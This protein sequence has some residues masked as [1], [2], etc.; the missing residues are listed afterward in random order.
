MAAP[1]LLEDLSLEQPPARARP[2]KHRHDAARVLTSF[3]V[4]RISFECPRKCARSGGG[5]GRDREPGPSERTAP[6]HESASRPALAVD[7]LPLSLIAHPISRRDSEMY[8]S[9]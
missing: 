2:A 1:P 9:K 8:G 3:R 5:S 7:Y 4:M 6:R